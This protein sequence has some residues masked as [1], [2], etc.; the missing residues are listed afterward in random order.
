M[1]DST[2]NQFVERQTNRA[3]QSEK[4]SG[5]PHVFMHYQGDGATIQKNDQVNQNSSAN[6]E[7]DNPTKMQINPF[8][9]IPMC[10]CSNFVPWTCNPYIMPMISYYVSWNSLRTSENFSPSNR[11]T[12]SDKDTEKTKETLATQNKSDL[13]EEQCE[14]KCNTDFSKDADSKRV[15]KYE[16]DESGIQGKLEKIESKISKEFNTSS[17]SFVSISSLDFGE[18]IITIIDRKKNEN[19]AQSKIFFS[20]KHMAEI[21]AEKKNYDHV[22][23]TKDQV[24]NQSDVKNTLFEVVFNFAIF[25]PE[26]QEVINE[27]KNIIKSPLEGHM[28]KEGLAISPDSLHLSFNDTS[29]EMVNNLQSIVISIL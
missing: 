6:T 16:N 19:K 25:F 14:K 28:Y 17:T 29:E 22:D 11:G 1:A 5:Q 13:N 15:N 9:F 20:S 2:S 27:S 3:T 18:D 26:T 23:G 4:I 10:P 24:D 7:A 12:P 8:S 21:S